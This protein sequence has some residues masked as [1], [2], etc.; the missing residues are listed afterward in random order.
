MKL[1]KVVVGIVFA[2]LAYVFG[3]IVMGMLSPALHLPPIKEVP[4]RTPQE[5]LLLLVV[6]SPLLA[7]GLLPLAM[8]IKGNWVQRSLAIAA[9][10]YV[11]LGLNTLLELSIFSTLLEGSPLF[12]SVQWILPALL[13]AAALTWRFRTSVAGPAVLGDFGINW[14]WRLGLAWLLFPV[15]YFLFGM[16]VGPFVAPYYNGHDVL[17]LKIPGFG[18]IIRMQL[19]RSAI[20][21]AASLPA[22]VLWA[23][24][25]RSLFFALGLAHAMTVGIFQLAQAWFLPM[26]LR[27]AH[28]LEITAD[29]F[30]YAAVLTIL[31][32]RSKKTIQPALQGTAAAAD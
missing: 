11:T 4:G 6:C 27:V 28:S 31:L 24:S 20:F 16:C 26:T 2:S 13:M 15:I 25:R 19:L 7:V 23:K 22:I 14:T 30:A 32:T 18:T 8:G 21:L 3:V 12:A 10:V 1:V 17:G 5:L 29:S 9:L